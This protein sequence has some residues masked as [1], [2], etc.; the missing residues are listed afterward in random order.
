[1]IYLITYSPLISSTSNNRRFG[2]GSQQVQQRKLLLISSETR[3]D[4][5]F[6]SYVRLLIPGIQPNPD[7]NL[8]PHVDIVKQRS[9]WQRQQ[10]FQHRFG[11][12]V[13]IVQVLYYWEHPAPNTTRHTLIHRRTYIHPTRTTTVTLVRWASVDSVV[14]GGG[15]GRGCV[16]GIGLTSVAIR[17]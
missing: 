9:F 12:H 5:C 3:G 11:K 6:M 13:N 17:R 7:H 14:G 8:R 2:L 1:M 16:F 4:F 15:W 10:P